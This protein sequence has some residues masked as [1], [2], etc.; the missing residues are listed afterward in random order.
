LKLL[1]DPLLHFVVAGAILFASYTLISRDAVN[2][3]AT[4]PIHILDGDISWLKETFANQWRRPPTDEEMRS[5]VAGFLDEQLLAR[6]AKALGLDQNDTIVRRRLAQKLAFLVDDTSRLADPTD[7]ELRQFYGTYAKRFK[8]EARVSFKQIFFNPQRRIHAEA[9]A[10]AALVSVSATEGDDHAKT[11]GDPILLEGE[12]RDVDAQTVSNLFGPEFAHAIFSLKPGS[13]SGPVQSGYGVH[14][15]RVTGL[16][17]S[18]LRPF[19]EIR[20]K[21]LEE[22][23]H[24]QESEA[25]AQYL[26]KLRDKYG[27]AVDS[28]IGPL[29]APAQVGATP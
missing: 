27:V 28:T 4:E 24:Q 7:D 14:L 10:E 20:S 12:F 16:K 17:P 5:L 6:E 3:P 25:K 13:W 21:V 22:W 29:L 15:V 18:A 9:D 1:K 26:A 23:R 8:N 2:T 19:E 11:M